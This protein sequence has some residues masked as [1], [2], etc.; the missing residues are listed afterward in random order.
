MAAAFS[1]AEIPRYCEIISRLGPESMGQDR[2]TVLLSGQDLEDLVCPAHLA[3]VPNG[4]EGCAKKAAN[5][6]P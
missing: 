3:R 6:Q 1:A 2:I 4:Q 5:C